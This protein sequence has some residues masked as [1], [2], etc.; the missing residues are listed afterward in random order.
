[1]GPFTA[2]ALRTHLGGFERDE[3]AAWMMF[4]QTVLRTAG[5]AGTLVLPMLAAPASAAGYVAAGAGIVAVAAVAW[6]AATVFGTGPGPP[7]RTA[8]RSARV[9]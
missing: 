2:V 3:R 1:M 6:A 7:Q 4:D 8:T 9:I 5:T